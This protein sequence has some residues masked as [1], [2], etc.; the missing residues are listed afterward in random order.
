MSICSD[1][2]GH[3]TGEVDLFRAAVRQ[4]ISDALGQGLCEPLD[5]SSAYHLL[6][7]DHEPWREDRET[8]CSLAAVDEATLTRWSRDN[9][10]PQPAPPPLD[11]NAV[12]LLE[13]F[14]HRHTIPLKELA[15][16]FG[17]PSKAVRIAVGLL[18]ANGWQ[19]W[20]DSTN[21][22]RW[23]KPES[24][25]ARS[26]LSMSPARSLEEK[27]RDVLHVLDRPMT[28]KMVGFA[29]SLGDNGARAALDALL[30][31]GYVNVRTMPTTY[32]VTDA[33]R[34]A[35]AVRGGWQSKTLAAMIEHGK[36]LSMEEIRRIAGHRSLKPLVADRLIARVGGVGDARAQWY[37]RTGKQLPPPK[38]KPAP[39]PKIVK[40]KV[41]KKPKPKIVK[42]KVVK[43]PK[44][45]IVKPKRI[46]VDG[47]GILDVLRHGPSTVADLTGRLPIGKAL[48]HRLLVQLEHE[49]KAQR[50]KPKPRVRATA[51]GR[52]ALSN[53]TLRRTTKCYPSLVA[54]VD[55]GADGI[56]IERI[57]YEPYATL[58]RQGYAESIGQQGTKRAEVWSL[59]ETD[60]AD[61]P[62]KLAA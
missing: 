41:V 27:M 49:G 33:G 55:A 24:A 35:V 30:A 58:I 43:K 44:P 60:Q 37:C 50:E 31:G 42:P 9:L 25:D 5:Q 22:C 57:T 51:A 59:V 23:D 54:L 2:T 56:Q 36:P 62:A 20:I 39:E 3:E 10:P 7:S 1:L 12:S 48:V 13:E 19:A 53:A 26:A 16:E 17:M 47:A 11:A 28:A 29:T 8:L 46:R 52:A 14:E 18:R 6:T 32:R 45:K 21:V 4:A 40:P 61:A 15:D 34:S 38:P